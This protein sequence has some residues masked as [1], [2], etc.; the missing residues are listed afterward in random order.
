MLNA[1]EETGEW[2][3][4][5]LEASI[6]LIP[7]DG[8]AG[9]PLDLRPI[10]VTSA[11]YRLW[12]AARVRRVLEWQELWLPRGARGFRLSCGT[13]DVYYTLALRI[14]RT[15]LLDEPL[16]GLGLDL[17]KAFDSLPQ[18]IMLQLCAALGMSDR[19]LRP[20]RTMYSE[21]SEKKTEEKSI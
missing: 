14:E 18:E 19:I 5:L 20:L 17:A 4:A 7:K 3:D 2:P 9:G 6:T 11:L 1:F 15:L 12:A 10:T 13:D 16:V 8:A 21:K